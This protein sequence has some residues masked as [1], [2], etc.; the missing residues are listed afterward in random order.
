MSSPSKSSN[1]KKYDVKEVIARTLMTNVNDNNGNLG[2][3]D[4]SIY[5]DTA[6]ASGVTSTNNPLSSIDLNTDALTLLQNAVKDID[7]TPSK[8]AAK[9]S[10]LN[11]RQVARF[12]FPSLYLY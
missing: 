8:R 12:F 1:V 7:G 3:L 5:S 9:R 11:G 2:L 4:S 6:R 10:K